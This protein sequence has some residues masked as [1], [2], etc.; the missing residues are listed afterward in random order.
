MGE[1]KTQECMYSTDESGH[2]ITFY[3]HY[4]IFLSG[5]SC[6]PNEGR[7]NGD[8]RGW[9]WQSDSKGAL[10]CQT[11]LYVTGVIP[12]K[13]P[14]HSSDFGISSV[15][16]QQGTKGHQ[17]A[18]PEVKEPEESV[19]LLRRKYTL[20]ISG[21]PEE[22]SWSTFRDPRDVLPESFCPWC[23]RSPARP[24]R[25]G[26]RDQVYGLKET[27]TIS[28]STGPG[29]TVRFTEELWL[30]RWALRGTKGNTSPPTWN[31]QAPGPRPCVS[32]HRF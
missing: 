25:R 28:S 8:W 6:H 1:E 4:R 20:N 7:M 32:T 19:K 10:G 11:S 23:H 30:H 22:N 13:P 29:T 2:W 9:L 14:F 31:L 18:L 3:T 24:A 16:L 15:S 27:G 17:T 21:L 12:G 5:F 26:A